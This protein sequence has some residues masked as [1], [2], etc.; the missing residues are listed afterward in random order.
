MAFLAAFTL[1]GID[2]FSLFRSKKE[3]PT[4]L[5]SISSLQTFKSLTVDIGTKEEMT[6]GTEFAQLVEVG[7]HLGEQEL[8]KMGAHVIPQK[9]LQDLVHAS[10]IT[11]DTNAQK[12]VDNMEGILE[13]PESILDTLKGY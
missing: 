2:I 11:N 1:F 12:V 5:N 10:S 8:L 3:S 9:T 6:K 7:Q 4:V 13:V